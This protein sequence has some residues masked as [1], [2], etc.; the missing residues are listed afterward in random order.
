M[1]VIRSQVLRA[2][3]QE[4]GKGKGGQQTTSAASS[5]LSPVGSHGIKST[6]GSNAIL[7]EMFEILMD[8][9]YHVTPSEGKA[10]IEPIRNFR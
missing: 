8:E 1:E 6:S 10:R 4:K 7:V 9:R 5:F 2:E 3:E